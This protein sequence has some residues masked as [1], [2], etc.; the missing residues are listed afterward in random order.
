LLLF[1][2][3]KSINPP[4]QAMTAVGIFEEL[5]IATS[6]RDLL[7]MT[8]GRSVYS[9]ADLKAWG[10]EVRPVKVINF[11]LAGYLHPVI[12]LNV[13]TQKSIFS[14]HP[15]QSIFE[16]RQPHLNKLL[17]LKMGFDV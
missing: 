17:P 15:P 1:Y 7:Q 16:I 10:A 2:K 11:L 14:R 5:S 8:G 13:L 6:T 9:E 3:G 12:T 4:S